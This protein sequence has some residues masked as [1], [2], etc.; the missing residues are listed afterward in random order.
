MVVGAIIVVTATA[1]PTQSSH[2]QLRP[3]A[4]ARDLG[5]VADLIAHAFADELDERS[6]AALRELRWM[7]RLSPLVWWLAQAD[8]M[9]SESLSG[10][11]W[12]EL[13]P[14]GKGGQIVGNVSLSRAPG[15][16][17]RWI[18]SNVVVRDEWRGRGIG[19]RLAEAA[20]AK[21]Q[22]L[23]ARGVVLQVHEDNFPALR[24]YTDLGFQEA[25]GET[26]LRLETVVS[27]AFLDAPGYRLRSWQPADGQAAYELAQLATPMARQWIRPV[28]ANA[29]RWGWWTRLEQAVASLL[30]G[31]RI[32]RLTALKG[33]QLVAVMTLTAAFRRGG[34]RL[35]L[36]VHPD[37]AGQIEAGLVSR[38]LYM[39]A[40]IPARPVE[41]VV[42]KD[43]T[44]ALKAMGD[45]GFKE[46]RT[47][48]TLRKDF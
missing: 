21:A 29:Y 38:A 32:Y 7:A 13:S 19:R 16:R 8:P 39:L 25:A 47:L 31:R 3:L 26:D 17:Q 14:T 27:V 2:G 18:I 11:V 15:S 28:S 46:Q 24:L 6:R 44:A 41:A 45:Y 35:A 36:L 22:E 42:D 34:H 48:L 40:A 9:F 12:E 1:E 10:F 5:A 30:A 4:P 33:E 20:I 37:H 23:G 43:H